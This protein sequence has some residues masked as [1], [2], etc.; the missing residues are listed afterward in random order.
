VVEP[1]GQQPGSDPRVLVVLVDEDRE[2][3]ATGAVGDETGVSDDPPVVEGQDVRP[4]RKPLEPPPYGRSTQRW[5]ALG[6]V[7]GLEVLVHSAE[8]LAVGLAIRA[9]VHLPPLLVGDRRR[10]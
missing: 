1:R 8:R 7:G 5:D 3:V 4:G 10:R 9:E 2:F 6:P